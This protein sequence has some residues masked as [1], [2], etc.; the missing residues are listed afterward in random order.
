M[1]IDQSDKTAEQT[2][3]DFNSDLD[4]YIKENREK[5]LCMMAY[6]VSFEFQPYV[7]SFQKYFNQEVILKYDTKSIYAYNVDLPQFLAVYFIMKK[8]KHKKSN[9]V[10]THKECLEFI[11]KFANFNEHA[12]SGLSAIFFDE[13][14]FQK[15]D[16]FHFGNEETLI[17]VEFLKQ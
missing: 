16:E 6:S 5:I 14:E 10:D 17:D 2:L 8:D 11:T 3:K 15:I 4:S 1:T 9:N 13:E 12:L 7:A